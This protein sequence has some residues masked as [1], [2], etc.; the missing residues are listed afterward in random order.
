MAKPEQC[1]GDDMEVIGRTTQDIESSDCRGWRRR[2][3]RDRFAACVSKKSTL[4]KCLV[5]RF[6]AKV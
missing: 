4:S 6:V 5:N 2:A 3:C 1:K